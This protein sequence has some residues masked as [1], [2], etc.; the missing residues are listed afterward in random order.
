MKSN[1]YLEF[2]NQFRGDSEGINSHFSCYDSLL[3]LIIDKNKTPKIIDIGCGRGEWLKRWQNKFTE[4]YGIELDSKMIELCRDSGLNVIEGDAILSLSKVSNNSISVI[5]IFH[6][7]EH[8]EYTKLF[9]LIKECYRVLSDNGVL[10]I[11]T[12]SIDNLLVSSK[13]FYTDPTHITHINPDTLL[14][15]IGKF[16]FNKANYYYIHPG[17]LKNANPSKITR[18]LN[19][20]A[21]DILFVATKSELSSDFIFNSNS[22]WENDLDIGISTLD[23]AI[24]H[25]LTLEESYKNSQN[26]IHTMNEEIILL[27]SQ[28]KYLIYLNN[29][30]KKIFRPVLKILRFFNRVLLYTCNKIFSFLAK[31]EFIR[32]YLLSYKFLNIIKFFLSLF[33]GDSANIKVDQIKNK[34]NKIYKIDIESKRFNNKLESHFANSTKSKKYLNILK[35]EK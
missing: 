33:L 21:Q 6:M 12:P 27:K 34:F 16:G 11:E 26:L 35:G 14:F 9:D 2:E 1:L 25:D 3:E 28:L 19:G 30:L 23:A 5:T 10:I 31:F 13:L 32:R 17:P 7:I 24:D 8:M 20:V 29:I 4:C 15:F 22:S 18:I